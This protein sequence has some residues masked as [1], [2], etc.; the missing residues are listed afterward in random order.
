MAGNCISLHQ[1]QKTKLK[2]QSQKQTLMWALKELLKCSQ[3]ICPI[4]HCWLS[5][6]FPQQR[7]QSMYQ[8]TGL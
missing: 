2:S 5:P 4:L 8:P 7:L 1:H 3:W 6:P